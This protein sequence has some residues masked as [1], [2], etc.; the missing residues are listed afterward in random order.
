MLFDKTTH[1]VPYSGVFSGREGGEGI[2]MVFVV[3]KQTTKYLP[4]KVNWMKCATPIH[5]YTWLH[6]RYH[7]AIFSNICS[8]TRSSCTPERGNP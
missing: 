7:I 2:I 6:A 8:D 4:T 3:E 5:A 1:A